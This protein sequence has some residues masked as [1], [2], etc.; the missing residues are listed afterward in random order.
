MTAMEWAIFGALCVLLVR[1]VVLPL[2]SLSSR[3][4]SA[5]ERELDDMEQAAA[6]SRPAPLRPHVKANTAYGQEVSK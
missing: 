5:A 6:V 2:V 4:R 3:G 1:F